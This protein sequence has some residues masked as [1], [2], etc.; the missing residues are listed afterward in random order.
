MAEDY[1]KEKLN[2]KENYKVESII[3]IGYKDEVKE[4]INE[5]KLDFHKIHV[6]KFI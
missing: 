5:E 6:N 4:P 3:A 1:I 2:I